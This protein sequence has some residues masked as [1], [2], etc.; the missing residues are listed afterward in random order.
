MN[1]AD[2]FND[3]VVRHVIPWHRDSRYRESAMCAT[4]SIVDVIDDAEGQI[5]VGAVEAPP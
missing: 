5:I 3:P 4:D 1:G 2:T